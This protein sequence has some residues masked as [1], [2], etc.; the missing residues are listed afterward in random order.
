MYLIAI[1]CVFGWRLMRRHA[2]EP[3]G[4]WAELNAR[5]TR[6]ARHVMRLAGA[7]A[8]VTEPLLLVT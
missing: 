2:T 8:I 6:Q 7:G 4:F 1:G 3:D 5:R